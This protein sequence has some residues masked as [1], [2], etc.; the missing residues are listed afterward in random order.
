MSIIGLI[1]AMIGF[2]KMMIAPSTSNFTGFISESE[3]AA[4]QGAA[5]FIFAGIIIFIISIIMNPEILK[6]IT[7]GFRK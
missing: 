7:E 2:F 4:K 6:T 1:V 3:S 5:N